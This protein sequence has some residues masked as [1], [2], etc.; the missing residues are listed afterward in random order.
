MPTQVVSVVKLETS[1]TEGA[2]N[3]LVALKNGEIRMYNGKTLIDTL[4]TGD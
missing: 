1:R 2:N 4:S 3:V